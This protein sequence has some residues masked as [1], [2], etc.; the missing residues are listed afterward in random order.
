MGGHG[1]VRDG[2]LRRAGLVV[3][4][5]LLA[6]AAVLGA[7][8]A[9]ADRL[10]D[11]APGTDGAPL[12]SWALVI[13]MPVTWILVGAGVV[14]GRFLAA[15]WSARRW[16]VGAAVGWVLLLGGQVGGLIAGALG[17]VPW[18]LSPGAVVA[19]AL[20]AAVAGWWAAGPDPDLPAAVG[21]PGPAAP[22]IRLRPG[23]R[24]VWTRA[25]VCPRRVGQAVG[26]AGAVA[27]LCWVNGHLPVA[28]L[29]PS[30]LVLALLLGQAWARVRV[31][32]RGVRVEQPLVRR[33]LV[34]VDL[35]HVT[36][37]A[38]EVVGP[39]ALPRGFGVLNADRAWGYRATRGGELLRLATTDGRDFVVTVPDAATAAA[40]VNAELDR[41]GAPLC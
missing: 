25:V 2:R 8:A 24:A 13:G 29:A 26:W 31:D 17:P 37:A 1:V 10:S 34:G 22:R 23:E 11:P 16:V 18:W 28:Y 41:R 6:S 7:Y 27:V 32:A 39:R 3:A 33:T 19:W 4:S 9:L 21:G 36:E 15:P 40:L 5:G 35:A 20:V 12:S 14:A 38:A 30:A